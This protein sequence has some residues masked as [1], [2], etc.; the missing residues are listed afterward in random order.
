MLRCLLLL[1]PLAMRA[2]TLFSVPA[3]AHIQAAEGFGN[4]PFPISTQY[5][6][7]SVIERS[8]LTSISVRL[9]SNYSSPILMTL[10]PS[11]PDSFVIDLFADDGGVLHA[12]GLF[13]DTLFGRWPSM[14]FGI[15]NADML[16]LDAT[17]LATHEIVL[18]PGTIYWIRAGS[19]YPG[20]YA[21]WAYNLSMTGLRASSFG[22]ADPTPACGNTNICGPL[23]F[24]VEGT[25]LPEPATAAMMVLAAAAFL[26]LRPRS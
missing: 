7:F 1:L 14:P 19:N 18:E 23:V 15:S 16:R 4:Y 22:G 17:A 5:V 10:Q 3:P 2:A 20:V 13:L 12:P 25:P 11:P 6:G 9:A 21:T 8:L 24:T 26:C